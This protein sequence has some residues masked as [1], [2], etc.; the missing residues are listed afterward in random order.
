MSRRIAKADGKFRRISVKVNAARPERSAHAGLFRARCRRGAAAAAHGRSR[1]RRAPRPR[2]APRRRRSAGAGHCARVRP[3]RR[4]TRARVVIAADVDVKSFL[5]EPED[6]GRSRGSVELA[7]AATR[8]ETGEVFHFE[9]TTAM[10][11]KAET[12]DRLGVT[13]Y[14]V[15]REFS[16]PTGPYQ[17]RVVIRDRT[18]GRIGSVTHEFEVPPL[19][20]FRV[21][22]PILTDVLQ[23]DPTGQAAPKPVLL[24]RRTFL[25][26]LHALLSV[27]GVRGRRSSRGRA[28]RGSAAAGRSSEATA[29]SSASR[30]RRH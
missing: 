24:A 19:T 15:S 28:S 7:V 29:V 23:T 9:Q 12:R 27:H 16:L 18:S 1:S 13:W 22:S 17:A 25:R 21:S 30:R 4:R 26:R 3:R 6:G 11:L 8:L 5:F 14:S 2:R 10:N 20:G